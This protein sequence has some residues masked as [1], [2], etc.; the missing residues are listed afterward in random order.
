MSN[1][2][3]DPEIDTEVITH[4]AI[5]TF[6]RCPRQYWY[7]YILRLKPVMVGV[8][9]RRGIWMHELLEAHHKGE[10]WRLKH[11]ELCAKYDELLDEEKDYYGDLPDDCYTLM[12]AYVYY[13]ANDPWETQETEFTINAELPMKS[14]LVV[15]RGRVDTLFTDMFGLWIGDHKTHLRLPGLSFRIL[16]AQSALYVWA[17]LESGLEVEGF[18]WNYLRT[19]GPSKPRVVKAGDRLYKKLG[20]TDYHTFG[21]TVKQFLKTGELK[22]MTPEIRDML[23][24]LKAEQYVPG[25]PQN[26]PFFRRDPLE[27]DDGML[28][29]VVSEVVHTVARIRNYPFHRPEIIERVVDR[30]CE[31]CPF[32]DLCTTELMGGNTKYLLKNRFK[33]GDPMDYYQDRI[34]EKREDE[35]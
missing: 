31:Y 3:V 26:S 25:E 13:Y 10:D 6:R 16:D 18:K 30:S 1:L 33:V 29:Q 7:K 21:V 22:R 12:R 11:V 14:A 28:N 35:S 5:K 19:V 34:P 27:K 9:L 2:Y 15:Y 4:S 8:P 23:A 24:R 20:D 17:A 32:T